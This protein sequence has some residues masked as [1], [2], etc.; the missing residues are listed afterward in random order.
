MEIKFGEGKT[1]YGT[2]HGGIT[3]KPFL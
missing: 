1:K 2:K 3:V